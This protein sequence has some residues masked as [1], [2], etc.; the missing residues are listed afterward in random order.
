MNQCAFCA[1][2]AGEAPATMVAE[3]PDAVAFRPL[4][5]VTPGHALVVPRQHVADAA[6]DPEVFAATARRAAE[7]AGQ[8][9]SSN[10]ITSAGLAATQSVFHLH[11]HVVPRTADDG[12]MVPWGTV[13]GDDPTAPHW[14]RLAQR[15]Q[16]E[17][18]RVVTS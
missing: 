9:P 4:T 15:L 5:P 13:Y 12:L 17:L 10:I 1:I 7:L 11:V 16:D 2:V 6:E 3:W 18:D 14:C 8:S